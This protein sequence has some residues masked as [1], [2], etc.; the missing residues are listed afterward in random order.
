MVRMH[1]A[2][3]DSDE[4]L[5]ARL[6]HDQFPEWAGLP[7]RRLPSDG[8]DNAM[9]RLGDELVARLPLI[10]WAVPQIEKE[11]VWLP[12]LAPHLPMT[13][14]E[15]LAT[16]EPA[17]GYPWPWAVYRWIDGQNAHP[18]HLADPERAAVEL[19]GF[20]HALRALRFDD[21]PVSPRA[22][23]LAA[24]DRGIRDAIDAVR[25]EFDARTLLEIWDAALAEPPWDGPPVLVH[26]D[27]SDGNVLQ[28]NG[29]LCAVIDFSAFG[30]GE[31]AN[32][33]DPAW[34][35]FSGAGRRAFRDALAP[36]DAT[37]TR[38]RGW[39]VKCVYGL[40]YYRDTNPGIVARC[41]RRLAAL[42]EEYESDR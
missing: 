34:G 26:A 41:R 12:L 9:Y 15:Q 7:I 2:Q 23:N 42:L 6:L 19:A 33:L 28:R 18:D 24:D 35:M 36:D 22:K 39:A 16:G 5:V 37:W 21:P 10:D 40:V 11:R 3:I 14:P 13:I 4:E 38:A 32:D 30:F 20:V 8:T 31:P 25:D 29:E 17:H 27:L 1:D